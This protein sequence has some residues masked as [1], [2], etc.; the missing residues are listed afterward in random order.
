MINGFDTFIQCPGTGTYHSFGQKQSFSECFY[1]FVCCARV[2]Q[3]LSFVNEFI[4][5]GF[6]RGHAQRAQVMSSYG[7]GCVCVLGARGHQ[8][9][10]VR[11]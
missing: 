5:D 7:T 6:E 11:L 1:A 8:V 2:S 10:Q 9:P 4:L 3:K